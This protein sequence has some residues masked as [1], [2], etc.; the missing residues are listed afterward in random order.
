MGI[1]RGLT[2]WVA[3]A[4][5]VATIGAPGPAASQTAVSACAPG[6]LDLRGDFGTIRLRVE[7]A[8]TPAEQA[9]GLMF[10]ETL[11]RLAGM[12][13]VYPREQ[14]VAFWMRN[15]LI[16]LDMI[17]LDGTGTV[18]RVH[19]NAVPLDET[20]IPAGAPALAVLEINGGLAAT[21]GIDAG[22]EL[23]SPEMPQAKAAW[24]CN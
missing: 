15:T 1:F 19:E 21:I 18:I 2:S 9:R 23:R 24:S 3:A 12:L 10:R 14:A 13:F 22:D 4:L 17:F 16:P 8:R 7:I 6:V 20:P 11:P 5:V